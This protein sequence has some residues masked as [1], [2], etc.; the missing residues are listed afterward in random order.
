[1]VIGVLSHCVGR[2][3]RADVCLGV[4]GGPLGSCRFHLGSLA[5]VC[6]QQNT[7]IHTLSRV[8][9]RAR[10][11]T[12]LDLET[13]IRAITVLVL[14]ISH[15]CILITVCVT[16][17]SPALGSRLPCALGRTTS[18]GLPIPSYFSL[19]VR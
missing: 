18:R 14:R 7:N 12:M 6:G 5:G 13:R 1:M 15:A 11:E 8:E 3:A 16:V 4:A 19:Y 9:C 2:D 17:V 10:D